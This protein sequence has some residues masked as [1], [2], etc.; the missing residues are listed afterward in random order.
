VKR[1]PGRKRERSMGER[2][3][4][5]ARA[6]ARSGRAAS[7]AERRI[8]LTGF[9]PFAGDTVNP[10]GEVAK[11][12]DGRRIGRI[13]VRSIVLPVLH[14]QAREAMAP[15][16]DGPEV[17]A[18][19]HLGLAGGRA[20]V[21]L[22]RVG[23]NVMHYSMPDA[24][25][26]LRRDE[27][28]VLGGPAAYWS[29]LP[30]RSILRELT[31]HGIPAYLSYTAGTYLCNFTLY[32]TLHAVAERRPPVRAGFIHLP[33][34]PSMVATHGLEEPSMDLVMMLQAVEIALEITASTPRSSTSSLSTRPIAPSSARRLHSPPAPGGA[35]PGSNGPAAG[36]RSPG[37]TD[38]R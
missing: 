23:V 5:R 25:G 32:S 24:R 34:L 4:T 14:E 10:S 26:D 13:R 35:W 12:L 6:R 2:A 20:R 22:E 18:V 17:E 3:A 19:V 1:T 11:A 27:P 28:C 8:V 21:A 38:G 30:L 33:Y 15:A 9:E 16:L 36:T 29:T 31:A 7:G 37:R